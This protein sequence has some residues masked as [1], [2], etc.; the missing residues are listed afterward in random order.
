[1]A[2][3]GFELKISHSL[4]KCST[5]TPRLFYNNLRRVKRKSDIK[6]AKERK[7]IHQNISSSYLWK[8]E[9]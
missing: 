7:E 2:V 5:T 3:L 4:D 6:N 9:P 1:L 8:M